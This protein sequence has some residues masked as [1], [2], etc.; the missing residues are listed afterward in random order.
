MHD[1]IELEKKGIPST[2]LVTKPFDTQAKAM[3]TIL[4]LPGFRYT[5]IDHPMGSLNDE[6]IMGRARQAIDQVLSQ[7]VA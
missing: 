6:Q 3:T 2:V 1:A 4:G 7:I 5:I